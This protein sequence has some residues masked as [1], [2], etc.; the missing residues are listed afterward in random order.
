MLKRFVSYSGPVGSKANSFQCSIGYYNDKKGN[1]DGDDV[2]IIVELPREKTDIYN[3]SVKDGMLI[4][5]NKDTKRL[6]ASIN[7]QNIAPTLL[8]SD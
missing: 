2:V 5:R 6:V 7:L 1:P 8:A 4:I 3:V